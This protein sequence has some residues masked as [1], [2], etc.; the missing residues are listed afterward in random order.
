MLR[1]NSGMII[2]HAPSGEDYY[3][4]CERS[5]S[6]AALTFWNALPANLPNISYLH[7][8]KSC[9]KIYYFKLAGFNVDMITCF[10]IILIVSIFTGFYVLSCA[11]EHHI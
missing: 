2:S 1:S 11:F 7:T 9:L 10:I 5:F 8:F 3:I 6:V 4:V